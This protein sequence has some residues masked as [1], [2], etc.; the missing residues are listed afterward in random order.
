MLWLNTD[1]KQKCLRKS[2]GEFSVSLA[3]DWGLEDLDSILNFTIDLQC[4][5]GKLISV[6]LFLFH[7]VYLFC[8][9][10]LQ[11]V[12]T[13]PRIRREAILTV[14][15]ITVIINNIIYK[16]S[17]S[18]STEVWLWWVCLGIQWYRFKLRVQPSLT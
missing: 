17:F 6:F 12:S 8:L 4:D 16:V 3:K 2:P 1:G 18:H 10:L 15:L 13:V 14:I 7:F 5:F 11:F 9:S